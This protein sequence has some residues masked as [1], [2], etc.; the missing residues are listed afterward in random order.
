MRFLFIYTLLSSVVFGQK[1]AKQPNCEELKGLQI[2]DL[3]TDAWFGGWPPAPNQQYNGVLKE[4]KKGKII[5][6]V[7]CKNGKL[8]LIDWSTNGDSDSS[9]YYYYSKNGNLNRK[10]IYKKAH[11]NQKFMTTMVN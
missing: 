3:S 9:I 4:C 11:L 1:T 2:D 6:Y 5:E 8:S 7:T 10:G